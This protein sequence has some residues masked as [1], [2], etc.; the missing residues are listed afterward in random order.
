MAELY[1]PWLLFAGENYYPAGGACDLHSMSKYPDLS[2]VEALCD[3]WNAQIW[4]EIVVGVALFGDQGG[5]RAEQLIE[6]TRAQVDERFDPF[7]DACLDAITGKSDHVSIA[8]SEVLTRDADAGLHRY[9][10]KALEKLG[11]DA[12]PAVPTLI[13]LLRSESATIRYN[14]VKVI[15]RIGPG[16]KQAIPALRRM[17]KEDDFSRTALWAIDQIR[18]P[19]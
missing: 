19:D 3:S 5:A 2:A 12:A 15:A 13:E 17:A 16:A 6:D 10:F 4:F 11:P 9:V 7:L 8:L 18:R 1:L 14:S